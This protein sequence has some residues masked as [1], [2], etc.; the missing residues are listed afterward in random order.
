MVGHF[1]T[2][3]HVASERCVENRRLN[4]GILH[5]VH[6]L[7]DQRPGLPR[8]GTTRFHDDAQ[9]R[10]ARAEIVE[11]LHQQLHI[12]VRTRHQ[13]ATAEVDPLQAVEPSAETRL[14]V[15]QRVA[16]SL[17]AALTMAVNVE[18]A[19]AFRQV[20]GQVGT[21]QTE[22]RTRCT[23]IVQRCLNFRIFGVHAQAAI[24]LLIVAVCGIPFANA[25]IE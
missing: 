6:H 2:I 9:M 23:R 14:D 25:R 13:V 7:C 17:T 18:T 1:E 22:A 24:H 19:D 10:M 3:G 20:G 4:P 15:L 16:K 11:Q 8:K 5:H 21:E 12:I